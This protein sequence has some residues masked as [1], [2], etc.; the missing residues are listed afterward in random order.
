MASQ[1]FV[2]A[3]YYFDS[4]FKE[5]ANKEFVN[6][7]KKS[8]YL[9][10]ANFSYALGN[11]N[12]DEGLLRGTFGRVRKHEFGEVYDKQ[13]KEFKK[14]QLPET[15]DITL[16]FIISH[17]Q[18]IILFESSTVVDPAYF[19]SKFVKIYSNTSS[20][21]ELVIDF[22]FVER[23]VYE[24]IKSWDRVE[25]ITFKKLRPS[26]PSSLDD[27]ADIEAL[28]KETKSENTAIEFQA[29]N[30]KG[31]DPNDENKNPNRG[32][33]YESKLIKQGLALSAN[34]YGDAKIIGEK[35][36][37]R[38]EVET[39]KFHKRIDVDF[40]EDG[41]IKKITQIIQEIAH[42]ENDEGSK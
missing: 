6:D 8:S 22:I 41:A 37:R 30:D 39:R 42:E 5:Q 9:E 18:H 7:L 26:N 4:L 36:G 27:F 19:A 33:N 17:R 23:D 34:G 21:A 3:R 16:E 2:V 13:K 15:A 32:L 40:F 11:L 20:L 31:T 35:E 38:E 10:E 1:K 14:K 29:A 28:L 24:T 25:K 12:E